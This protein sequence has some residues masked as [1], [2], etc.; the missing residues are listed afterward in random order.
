MSKSR[1]RKS[2]IFLSL[3]FKTGRV[4]GRGPGRGQHPRRENVHSPRNSAISMNC[5][6]ETGRFGGRD[7][8]KS[9]RF[10]LRGRVDGRAR[11]LSAKR[12]DLSESRPRKSANSLNYVLQPGRVDGR[13][14]TLSAKR[15][16]LA[17]SRPRKSAI[18]L[19]CVRE[20]GRVDGRGPGRGEHPR[21]VLDQL[22]APRQV[23]HYDRRGYSLDDRLRV[24][25]LN[26]FSF[27]T[28][29][30]SYITKYRVICHQVY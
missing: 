2:A 8:K 17:E 25:W 4:D 10:A 19:S 12:G 13:A 18:W 30:E 24:S 14:R 6:R 26:G 29:R 9:H 16:D 21:G 27:I 20:T 28:G 1:P 15:G 3:V 11:I 22:L 7:S 23:P 5:V